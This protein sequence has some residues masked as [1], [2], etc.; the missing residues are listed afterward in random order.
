M[1]RKFLTFL[2]FYFSSHGKII[3]FSVGENSKIGLNNTIQKGTGIGSNVIISNNCILR[4][5]VVVGNNSTIDSYTSINRNTII[6][7]ADIGP[8]CSIGQNCNIGPGIHPTDYISTSQNVYGKNN[9]FELPEN[10]D[11][12]YKKTII[13]EDVWIG[14][15]CTIMQGIL[16]S[17]GSIIGSNSVVTKDTEPY[18]INVGSPSKKIQMRFNKDKIDYLL[19]FKSILNIDRKTLKTHIIKGSSWSVQE[20]KSYS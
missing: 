19:S 4:R 14:A 8:F 12:F 20:E 3:L 17:R 2:K 1:L 16:I 11:P 7:F 6:D 10:F 15:N 13:E 5:N 9:I 18:S